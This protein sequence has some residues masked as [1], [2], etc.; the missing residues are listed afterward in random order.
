[1]ALVGHAHPRVAEAVARHARS[2]SNYAALSTPLIELAERVAALNPWIERLRF[3]TSGSE[4]TLTCVRIARG[5]SQRPKLMKFDGAFHGS[6]VEGVANFGWSDAANL[7][8]A[9]PVGTGGA[10]ERHG[11]TLI[12]DEVVSGF[13]LAPGGAAEYFGVSPDLAAYGKAMGGGCTIWASASGAGSPAC[14]PSTAC[15]RRSSETVRSPSTTSPTSRSPMSRAR[16]A[17]IER[18]GARSISSSF[19]TACSSTR[20]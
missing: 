5:A 20:C 14:S 9:E 19:A 4:A 10:T 3:V 13:R 11:V 15:P 1:L 18:P 2:A 17:P 12:F 8:A 16:R 6:H 7:P